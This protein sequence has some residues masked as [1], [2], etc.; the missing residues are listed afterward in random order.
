MIKIKII[1]VIGI[2]LSC[3]LSFAQTEKGGFIAGGNLGFSSEEIESSS[4]NSFEQTITSVNI[5]PSV[6]YFAIDRLSLGLSL[7]FNY[8]E[9]EQ[10]Q[11]S[12]NKITSY[13]IGPSFRYYFNFDN[14]SLFPTLRYSFGKQI[15][16]GLQFNPII[17]QVEDV[18]TETSINQFTG[19]VGLAFF[20][21]QNVA[22]EGILAYSKLNRDNES[23]FASDLKTTNLAFNVGLQF[24]F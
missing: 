5:N 3:N 4:N 17:G 14:F 2:V 23:E 19:G 10:P 1:L 21:N 9:I 8:S 20:L 7:P 24:Y 13:M 11:G 6:S 15:S 22:I 16:D 18:K 12:K